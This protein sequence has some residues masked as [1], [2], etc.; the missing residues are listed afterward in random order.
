MPHTLRIPTRWFVS[1]S[2]VHMQRWK[3]QHPWAYIYSL[4][5]ARHLSQYWPQMWFLGGSYARDIIEC[6]QCPWTNVSFMESGLD[7]PWSKLVNS[8]LPV[9]NGTTFTWSTKD[10]WE[11]CLLI[12]SLKI[13]SQTQPFILISSD[14]PVKEFFLVSNLW[15]LLLSLFCPSRH[16]KFGYHIIV[17][18]T[19]L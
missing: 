15:N 1:M 18:I 4:D 19:P 17:A 12:F 16:E 5:N 9:Q 14:F 2:S 11:P 10:R 3:D 7:E 13:I 8:S 6:F